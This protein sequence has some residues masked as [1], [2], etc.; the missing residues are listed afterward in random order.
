MEAHALEGDF[1]LHRLFQRFAGFIPNVNRLS[2][3]V[4]DAA[5]AGHGSFKQVDYFR[6]AGQRPQQTLGQEHQH[7]VSTDVQRAFQGHHAAHG[8]G[9]QET[10]QDRHADHRNKRGADANS[11]AVCVHIGFTAGFQPLRF[12]VFGCE[13]LDGGNA[14]QVVGQPAR[15]VTDLLAHVGVQRASLALEVERAPDNQRNGSKRQQ[16]NER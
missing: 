3:Q 15:Q 5:G 4:Q 11:P 16:G 8:K 1:A 14:A 7:A 12:P 9:G 2:Q 10:R 13:T 6:K